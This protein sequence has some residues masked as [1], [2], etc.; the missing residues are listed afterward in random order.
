MPTE[1]KTPGVFAPFKLGTREHMGAV[2]TRG[3]V[4]MNPLSYFA[5][6][7][8]DPARADPD[9]GTW[10]CEEATGATLKVMHD[11]EWAD[12]GTMTGPIRFRDDQLLLANVYC[13]HARLSHGLFKPDTFGFGDAYVLFHKPLEF[14]DRVAQ[15][16]KKAAREIEYRLVEYVELETHT[17]PMG[18]F[19]KSNAFAGQSEFRIVLPDGDG[20]PLSLVLGDLRDIALIGEATDTL[21]LEPKPVPATS[22]V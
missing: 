10:H 17:G 1:T 20:K 3:V 9:E 2:L 22:A 5:K 7:D 13:M 15:A 18:P 19:R 14:L 6:L 8:A 12:V 4:Y 16:A 21:K 11:D